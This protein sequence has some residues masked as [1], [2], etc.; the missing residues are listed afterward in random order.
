MDATM[1]F[2]MR[3]F[4]IPEIADSAVL[5]LTGIVQQAPRYL[6]KAGN[7]ALMDLLTSEQAESYVTKLL[8][9]N[10]EAGAT[11]FVGFVVS[12]LDLHELSSPEAFQDQTLGIVLA[13][14]RNLLHTPGT[15]V[16]TD[17][18]CQT[19]LDAFNQIADRW[20]DWVGSTAIDQSL[21]F[22]ISEACMQ[23]TIK[24]RYPPQESE[25]PG[26]SWESDER[27]QFQDFRND[28]QDLLLASYSCI[29]S[30]L[31]EDLAASLRSSDVS[32][33]WEDFEARLYCLSA[34]SDVI[35]NN[36]AE[37]GRYISEIFSSQRW[38]LLVH[39][40]NT[41]PDLARQGAINF[42]SRNTTILQ[43]D[44]QYLLPCINFLFAS[45]HL[46]GSTTSASRAIS[47]L[48][49]K[50]RSVLVE[51]LPQFIS[52]LS[53]LT[54]IPSDERHRLFGA[55][56]A[57]IQGIPT[58]GDKVVP[59]V[60]TF[61][62]ISQSSEGALKDSAEA[63][64]LSAMDIL[65]TLAAVGK[66]LRAPPEESIDLDDQPSMD[67]TNFWAHGGGKDV[68]R[69]VKNAIDQALSKYP[70]EP[71]LIE[72]TCDI[73]KS[74]YT[75]LH[76]SLFKFDAEYSASFLSRNIRIDSPRIGLII[77][78][79]STFL[80]S[81]ASNPE[82]IRTEFLQLSSS[83]T[84]CQ[85]AL[86]DSYAATKLY[87]DHE[88]THSSLDFFTH[89][90]PKY[91]YFFSDKSLS[92]AWQVLFEFALL[93]LENPDTLPRR[94]SAQFWV[95]EA[96]PSPVCALL[97]CAFSKAAIFENSSSLSHD[98][99][100]NLAGCIQHY[101]ARFAVTL[102]RLVGGGAARSELDVLCEPLK[103][104]VA[105]QGVLGAVLLRQA[106]MTEG[107]GDAKAKRFV[108]QVI[109]LRGGRRTGQLL[110][111]FWVGSRGAAF[112]Y[113]G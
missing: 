36:A 45:L 111:E 79:A 14:L 86:L 52:S 66:G 3:C 12:L 109:T 39:N 106:V 25:H 71:L 55:V 63:G 4:S 1:I 61:A 89:V 96:A 17:E 51:A 68:Q 24:I 77:D 18:V 11:H 54:D 5:C 48:C 33:G 85:R 6:R 113:A 74:G 22:L 67:E 42:I 35:S 47:V 75:E 83:V 105:R 101:G 57:I 94:S 43:H 93:A 26:C 81:N 103:K 60:Q 10:F 15:A 69:S 91:G 73:L 2:I 92:K 30:G 84:W 58:E 72:A 102:L 70:E 41:S 88:F 34:L 80:A 82:I 9:G 21:K 31:I 99:S 23:Y 65:Q 90:L 56:A 16:L 87:D 110:K 20:S 62:L 97:T 40:V 76:P 46:P 8:Q 100:S 98:A 19:V 7:E 29:G 50:Q 32:A 107:G 78:T 38:N 27:A 44:G 13:I 49:H 108:E 95:S 53:M 112:A 59:L 104:L 28:V 37:F 64:L